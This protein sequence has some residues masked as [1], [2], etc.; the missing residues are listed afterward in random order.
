MRF[1]RTDK[2]RAERDQARA[3]VRRLET[4][5]YR[6]QEELTSRRPRGTPTDRASAGGRGT[7]R[8]GRV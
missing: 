7:P 8:R 1:G 6:L 5:V 4:E 3:D 2:L